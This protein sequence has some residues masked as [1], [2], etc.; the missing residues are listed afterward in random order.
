MCVLLFCI[1]VLLLLLMQYLFHHH[2]TC[3]PHVHNTDSSII[4]HLIPRN[5]RHGCPSVRDWKSGFLELRLELISSNAVSICHVLVFWKMTECAPC[6]APWGTVKIAFVCRCGINRG[7][8]HAES[9]SVF[10]FNDV[11]KQVLLQRLTRA[12]T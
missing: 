8:V 9:W 10:A 5:R 4:S 1:V 7:I 3:T 6:C 2:H 12:Y 11:Q